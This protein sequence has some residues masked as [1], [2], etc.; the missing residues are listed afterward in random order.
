MLDTVIITIPMDKLRITNYSRFGT[1]EGEFSNYIGGFRKYPNNPNPLE[2]ERGVYPRLTL[3]RRGHLIELKVEVSVPKLIFGNNVDELSECDFDQVIAILKARIAD[4]GVEI[5]KENLINAS[6]NSFHP[7][8][9]IQLTGGYT[10]SFVISELHKISL[11]KRLDLTKTDFRNQGQ[12]L[13]YY[14]N[15]YSVV[16]YDKVKDLSKSE[17]RSIDEEQ[18]DSQTSLFDILDKQKEILRIEVRLSTKRKMLSIL[19]KVGFDR[20]PVFKDIFDKNLCRLIVKYYWQEM[21]EEKNRFIFATMKKPI[22]I[23]RMTIANYPSI[24]IKEAVYRTGLNLI[25]SDD[26]GTRAF[27]DLAETI[28]TTRN[29]Y[30]ICEDIKSLNNDFNDSELHNWVLQIREAINEFETFKLLTGDVNNNKVS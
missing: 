22:S 29:W 1:T 23:M 5:D 7:S 15:S 10:S 30:R 4:M 25:C 8:K 13:H 21:I 16:V 20:K 11:N 19:E 18:P 26:G 9:N 2:K 17:G 14:S 3:M 28:S 27:R 6:V 12:I 24:E